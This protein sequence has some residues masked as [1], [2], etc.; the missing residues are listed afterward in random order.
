[1]EEINSQDWKNM[2]KD[3]VQI[4]TEKFKIGKLTSLD[5]PDAAESVKNLESEKIYTEN[6]VTDNKLMKFSFQKIYFVISIL[7]RKQVTILFYFYFFFLFF[8]F[9]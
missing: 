5:E 9:I 6:I 3:Q 7:K 2:F 1:M 4:G 8:N